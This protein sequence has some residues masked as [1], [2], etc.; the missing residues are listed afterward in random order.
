MEHL[1]SRTEFVEYVRDKLTTEDFTLIDIGC[2]GGIDRAWRSFGSRLKAFAFDPNIAEI[3]RL[4]AAESNRKVEY[5]A[6]F[7]G[8]PGDDLVGTAENGDVFWGRNPWGR[9][10]WTRLSAFQTQELQRSSTVEMSDLDKTEVNAWAQAKLATKHPIFMPDF[11][12][13]HNITDVDFIKIDVDGPDYL[14]LQSLKD[15]LS[16]ISV[17]GISIEVNFFGSGSPL[18]NTFHNVDRFM[19]DAGFDLHALTV[20]KYSLRALPSKYLRHIPGE[21]ISGKPQQGDALYLRDLASSEFASIAS[22]M[23]EQKLAKAAAI[24]SLASL[25]DCAAEIFLR[26]R[27]RL[28]EVFDVERALDLLVKETELGRKKRLT[29][30]QY[31]EAFKKDDHAFYTGRRS[32]GKVGRILNAIFGRT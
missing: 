13:S 9:N 19:R 16:E 7:V 3:Q 12:K 6:G 22:N 14:I 11:L 28:D 30:R 5:I 31:I 27:E 24:C 15:A 1:L 32:T 20:R 25:P 8:P 18:D 21:S 2:G 26:F 29:Y 4:A 23:S 17:L 10:P